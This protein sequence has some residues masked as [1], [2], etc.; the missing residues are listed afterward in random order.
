[1]K[2]YRLR[3]KA[4]ERR[5][6]YRQRPEYEQK[7]RAVVS[8]IMGLSFMLHFI[9]YLS[10]YNRRPAGFAGMYVLSVS[11][12]ANN[13]VDCKAFV[14]CCLACALSLTIFSIFV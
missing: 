6:L 7:T 8:V 12:I 3:S 9:R 10:I 11:S 2:E 13:L 5:R 1:M 14:Y 4:R